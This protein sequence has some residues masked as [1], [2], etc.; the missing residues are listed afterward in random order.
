MISPHGPLR[1]CVATRP[2]D[3]RKGIDGLARTVRGVMGLG[4]FDG[5]AFVFR[6]GRADRIPIRDRTGMVPVHKRLVAA[7]SVRPGMRDGVMKM[8]PARL[9]ARLPALF[10][11]L[12]RRPARPE[13]VRRPALAGQ[14]R[15]SDPV[16]IVLSPGGP[17]YAWFRS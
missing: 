4:P 1:V 9:P 8:S 5:A 2:V 11:G 12:D 16:S 3:F 10:G 17:P 6:S 7:K 13:R 14:L 15:R